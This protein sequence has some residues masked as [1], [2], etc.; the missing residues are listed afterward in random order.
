MIQSQYPYLFVLAG[1]AVS[2][3]SYGLMMLQRQ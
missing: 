2:K 3:K 1:N